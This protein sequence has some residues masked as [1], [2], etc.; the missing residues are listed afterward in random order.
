MNTHG[1][2]R[3]VR[4]VTP[5]VLATL[6]SGCQ[7]VPPGLQHPFTTMFQHHKPPQMT[8]WP[9]DKSVPVVKQLKAEVQTASQKVQDRL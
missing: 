5:F 2:T 3:I 6:L 7:T 8:E 1:W 9:L 4:I